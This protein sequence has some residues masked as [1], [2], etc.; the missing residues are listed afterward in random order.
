M[1]HLYALAVLGLIVSFF[2]F[3]APAQARMMDPGLRAP[4]LV[5]TV[6]CR[7]IRERVERPGGRVIFRT[8][9]EC[10]PGPGP[11]VGRICRVERERVV[12]PNGTV[13]YRSIR[14]CR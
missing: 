13:V 10:T 5:D 4:S 1:R 11:G 3:S 12:R 8:R 6:A 7:T 2:A 9:R 14:R